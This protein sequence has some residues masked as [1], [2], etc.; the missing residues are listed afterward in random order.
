[1][2]R[3]GLQRSPEATVL[4]F[5]THQIIEYLAAPYLLQVGAQIGGRVATPCYVAGVATL[6]A[7]TFSGKPLGGGRLPRPAHR[8]VDVGL[9]AFIAA[10]P[11]LFGFSENSAALVRLEALALALALLTWFTNYGPPQGVA[12]DLARG[13][14]QQAVRGAGAYVGRRLGRRRGGDG[15]ARRTR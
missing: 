13:L 7:A 10:A 12:R 5:F 2:G 9:I 8:I 3:F 1:M 6:L 11:F 15:A 14:K 4:P